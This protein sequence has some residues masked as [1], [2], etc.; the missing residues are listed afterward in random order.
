MKK[1]GWFDPF[2]FGLLTAVLLASLLPARGV[3][4]DIVSIAADAGIV[5]LFFMHGARLSRQAIAAGIGNWRLQLLVLAMTF[6][7]F[8]LLGVA[9]STT[10]GLSPEAA[11]GIIF[12]AILPS[13]VQSSIAFT[14]IARGNVPAAVCAATLSN[15]IGIGLTPILAMA[16]ILGAEGDPAFSLS[17][18]YSIVGQLLLPFVLGHLAR[19]WIG[20]WVAQRKRMLTLIDRG[21]ILLVVYSAFGAAVLGGLWSRM[22]PAQIAIIAAVCAVLLA[23][24]LSASWGLG[25]LF[26]LERADLVVLQ[27]SGSKKSLA[28]GVPIAGALLPAAQVGAIIFPLMLFHQMQ[29]IACAILARR[30]GAQAADQEAPQ[31]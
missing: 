19:P 14:S 26:G 18:V 16:L 25:R 31:G 29:L 27:F 22:P 30:Y 15:M 28:S 21:S 3:W 12:L 5:V 20:E 7:L 2:I 17:A 24:V 1:P 9:F 6:V 8:P 23:I 10:P 13:T 4:S 11:S